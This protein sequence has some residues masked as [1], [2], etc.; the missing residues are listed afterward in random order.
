MSGA[1]ICPSTDRTTTDRRQV[2]VLFADLADFTARAEHTDP[3]DLRELQTAFFAATSAPIHA[4]GGVVEKYI[5]DAVLAVFGVPQTHED[6]AVRAARAALAMHEALGLLNEHL[7]RELRPRLAMRIGLHTGLVVASVEPD[8]DFVITGDVVNLAERLQEAAEPGSVLVSAETQ[9]RIAHVFETRPL[10]PLH[11]R[12]RSEPVATWRVLSPISH[13]ECRIEPLKLRSPLVGRQAELNTLFG[14]LG[15]LSQGQGGIV[16]IIGEAGLGKSRLVA[17]ARNTQQTI[18]L[19]PHSLQPLTW[20]EGRCLSYASATAY[21]LWIDLLRSALK[22]PPDAPPEVAARALQRWIQE[23]CPG[24]C[25]E[26]YP[27]LARL[28]ALPLPAD[29]AVRLETLGPQQLKRDTFQAVETVIVCLA[30]RSPLPLVCEDLH[31]SDASSLELL[32]HLLPLVK[33]MPVLFICVYRPDS[34]HGSSRLRETTAQRYKQWHDEIVLQPLS[35]TETE[36]LVL[37]LLGAWLPMLP[38]RRTEPPATLA[39]GFLWHVLKRT[40]GNP[41]FVEEI[42]RAL[43]GRGTLVHDAATSTWNVLLD[44]ADVAAPDTL[45]GVLA[46][47]ID[48]LPEA[49]RHVLRLAAVIGRIFSYRL[50]ASICG[51]AST[52]EA[53]LLRLQC[54]DLIREGTGSPEREFSFK[55]ELTREAAYDSL[56]K[57]ERRQAHRQIAEALERLFPQR[58]E[59]QLGLLAYHWEHAE[60]PEK[61]IN[62][63]LRAGDQARLF[64]AHQEAIGFYQ[65]ALALQ[66]TTSDDEGAARTLMRLGLVHG[67]AFDFGRAALVSNEGFALWR[68]AMA[69]PHAAPDLPSTPHALRLSWYPW[70]SIEALRSISTPLRLQVFA[71]LVEETPALEVVPDVAEGWDVSPDGKTYTFHLRPDARWS[72]GAP[73]IA[74]DF[75]HGWLRV[76]HPEMA[77]EIADLFDDIRGARA[78]HRGM[79]TNFDDVGIRPVGPHT[80]VVELER[81]AAYFLHIMALPV[82][83]PTPSHL[84]EA[85]ASA[86]LSAERWVSNGPFVV[87][88]SQPGEIL[89]L[90]RNPAYTGHFTGNID[91]I[92]IDQRFQANQW[93]EMLELFRRGHLDILSIWNYPPEAHAA[94]SHWHAGA[95]LTAPS[96]TV[97]AWVFDVTRPPFDD[98]RVRR[99]FQRGVDVPAV[100]WQMNEGRVTPAT[101]G[102]LPP[103][104]PGHS[105]GLSPAFDLVEAQRLLA[106]AGF[107]GGS[108]FPP[109]RIL[110]ED[111]PAAA[112]YGGLFWGQ[113]RDN[114]GLTL[115]RWAQGPMEHD[116]IL[117]TATS[118]PANVMW[119]GVIARYPDPDNL[120]RVTGQRLWRMVGRRH[121]EFDRLVAEARGL[122]DHAA[123]M[124]LYGQA[125]AILVREAFISPQMYWPTHLLLQPWVKRYPISPLAPVYWKDAVLTPHS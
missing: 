58:V 89:A 113:I 73:V 120:L 7:V 94:A 87:A 70:N 118:P 105:P 95:V 114:L 11:V 84:S 86:E 47:R 125:D 77:D 30:P 60:E 93:E 98:I 52:L 67:A 66:R 28:L 45:H 55:H 56:L 121:A 101:G 33:Q 74:A 124:A 18:G 69:R 61:A 9:A 96:L 75:L 27:Y 42:L 106:E 29:V 62:Y 104:M 57:R 41:F 36:A 34:D 88:A 20:L 12:G 35:P 109:A 90:A 37:N 59:E 8:G 2:T 6:D 111:S 91:R 123:R 31:W 110:G 102:W 81:P 38:Q 103:G 107:R 48:A 17:E 1:T 25:R 100:I 16:T 82:A 10:G 24:Q 4:H 39:E 49:P 71:G 92:E 76:L 64:Y 54:D 122:R 13:T 97:G 40:D 14:A 68:Q 85:N 3:E 65:R 80:L 53:H 117:R 108:G 21:H 63:L 26:I 115:E 99:A 51:D 116:R 83:T 15:R 5:G 32:E 46:A 119:I 22:A 44:T 23:L 50:L 43:I 19:G 112:R 79:V 78:F 72:D